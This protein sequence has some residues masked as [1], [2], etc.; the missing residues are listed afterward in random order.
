MCL[1]VCLMKS[2]LVSDPCNSGW[3]APLPSVKPRRLAAFVS[4]MPDLKGE[5][6]PPWWSGHADLFD[7]PSR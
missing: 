6:C 4:G 1:D 7:V 5:K 2:S 3:R